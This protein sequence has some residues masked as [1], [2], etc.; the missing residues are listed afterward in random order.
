MLKLFFNHKTWERGVN[1][2]F[3]L[4]KII[5][6]LFYFLHNLNDNFFFYWIFDILNFSIFWNLK[7]ANIFY[8]INGIKSFLP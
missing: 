5:N 4:V 1:I 2:M 8:L 3:Y 6:K 7:S